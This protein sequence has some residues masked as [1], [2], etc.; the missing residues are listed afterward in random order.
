MLNNATGI[1]EKL[2]KPIARILLVA[3]LESGTSSRG[4]GA[5]TVLDDD[6]DDDDFSGMREQCLKEPNDAIQ[7]SGGFSWW[8]IFGF[9]CLTVLRA[10]L[11]NTYRRAR[12]AFESYEISIPNMQSW[13]AHTIKFRIN[14][15]L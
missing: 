13:M 1:L 5:V 12:D 8:M 4:V 15:K 7:Q 14:M 3:G 10:F 2:A 11:W 6:D 9:I